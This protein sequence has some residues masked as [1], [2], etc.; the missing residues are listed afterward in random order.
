MVIRLFETDSTGWPER[1]VRRK[2]KHNTSKGAIKDVIVGS[3]V[4]PF[5]NDLS[6]TGLQA[7]NKGIAK[8]S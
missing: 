5:E 7:M 3:F 4:C 6:D 2:T 1:I 8:A